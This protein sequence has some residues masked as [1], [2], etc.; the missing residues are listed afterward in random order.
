M[1]DEQLDLLTSSI[2]MFIEASYPNPEITPTEDDIEKKLNYYLENPDLQG[3]ITA[4]EKI[5]ILNK[6]MM[7]M[8]VNVES[9][10]VVLE[11]PEVERWLDDE[12]G[13]IKWNYWQAYKKLLLKKG[14]DRGSLIETEKV[15]D[16]VLDLSGNP[17][18]HK[19]FK[20]KGLVMGN[21]QSGKTESYLGLI[22]KE[23]D[24]GYKIIILLGGHQNGLR[25][26]TQLRVNEGV[27][28]KDNKEISSHQAEIIGVGKLRDQKHSI[29]PFTSSDKD[30]DNSAVEALHGIGLS[31]IDAP[32]IL[33][34]KKWHTVLNGLY[35][36]LKR[37][38]NLDPDKGILLEDAL[39]FIDDE[40][41]YATP[42]VKAPDR[43]LPPIN[44]EPDSDDDENEP[45]M[46]TETNGNIRRILS[47]FRRS[48]YVAYTA[49][50]F[51]NIFIHPDAVDEKFKDSILKDDLYPSDFMIKLHRPTAYIGQDFFFNPAAEDEDLMNS[52][53]EI[54]DHE[55]LVPMKHKKD[56]DV[57][58][59]PPSLR[60]AIESFFINCAIRSHRNQAS[61]H[62]TMMVNVSQ[63][64]LIQDKVTEKIN[65]YVDRLKEHI[66]VCSNQPPSQRNK[67]PVI[68]TLKATFDKR[69]S[70]IESFDEIANELHKT[71][72]VKV[73]QTNIQTGEGL[74]Y[75]DYKNGLWTIVIGGLKLSRGL[76]LEGLSV[77]YFARNSKGV[78]TLMQMCRWFG[79]HGAYADLCKVYLPKESIS[80]YTHITGVVNE[81]YHQLTIMKEAGKTPDDF[82]LKVRDHPGALMI[83]AANKRKNAV[84]KNVYMDMWGQTIRRMRIHA[85][86]A[87]NASNYKN[88][89]LFVQSLLE[90]NNFKTE[91]RSGSLIF[92]DVSHEGV[93]EFTKQLQLMPDIYP[94]ELMNSYIKKMIDSN[95]PKFKV[96]VFNNK[97]KGRT[98]WAND[99]G[100]T[101]SVKPLM[102]VNFC[103][104]DFNLRL[105]TLE[106]DGAVYKNRSSVL[107]DPKDEGY[108]LDSKTTDEIN[109]NFKNPSP[110]HFIKAK[111]RDFPTLN[112]Y[113]VSVG[114][115]N[116]LDSQ[117]DI[118]FT[119]EPSVVYSISFPL[120]DNQKSE[121]LDFI[122]SKNKETLQSFL[123]TRRFVDLYSSSIENY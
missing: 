85:D 105:R 121:T 91:E 21:V 34:V 110:F 112:I 89:Q 114:I 3:K 65:L 9:K 77:S 66:D 63:F 6:L 92:E 5:Q 64:N 72:K 20:R 19:A 100:S 24:A 13:K 22:N 84:L 16:E 87:I 71:I 97:E 28:G 23:I 93:I 30:F 73:I 1:N 58:D 74:N 45:D 99:L 39:L 108:Y 96:C 51:A 109:K 81:L 7:Q 35:A 36:W 37:T 83:T 32:I 31:H 107:S 94:D 59:L 82:G 61:N 8:A 95:M 27:I 56:F 122:K 25:K 60:E 68:Q 115:K 75:D 12:R 117:I 103:G 76:T 55:N 2:R 54:N 113:L 33:T 101:N 80:W 88:T 50:P 14:R 120:L 18:K 48:T 11:N 119:N 40:A 46:V 79:Y 106:K 42:N 86:S 47:L 111:E 90:N 62:M 29:V 49:T 43:S 116:K 123:V 52:V 57:G 26:H 41:D 102:E 17:K 53:I 10:A 38:N 104:H 67:N 69:Y 70:V 44:I 78:D 98:A 118:P 15:I 4:P